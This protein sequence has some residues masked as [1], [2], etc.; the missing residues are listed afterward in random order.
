MCKC[1]CQNLTPIYIAEVA[2][3]AIRGR[4]VGLYELGWQIGGIVGFWIN[5]GINTHQASN[6][7]AWIIPFAVQVIPATLFFVG[8]P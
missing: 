4:L 3:P 6:P 1:V 8:L 2:P 5:Y 7:N